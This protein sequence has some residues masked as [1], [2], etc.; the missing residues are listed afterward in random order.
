M[1]KGGGSHRGVPAVLI[2]LGALLC[3]N[4]LIY[5]YLDSLYQ[6]SNL[7]EHLYGDCPPGHFRVG[8]MRNCS[9]WLQCEAV[10]KEVRKLKMISQGAVKQV[11]LS[12]W[13]G[14]KVALSKLSSLDY[15]EDFLHGLEMLKALQSP[16]VVTLVGFCLDNHTIVT[17][18]QPL[19]SLLNLNAV[20]NLEK[21]SNVNTWQNRFRL[22]I[23]Y[24]EI[25]AFLHNSP[26]GVRVMC[27]SN[28]LGK[29]LSQYLLTTDFHLVANDLD[30]LPL[31]DHD[32]NIL[33]KCGP[34]ELLGEFVAPE[35][36]WPHGEE[37]QFTDGLMP[38]YDEKTDIWKIPDVV[39]F[40][41]G[42]VEGSDVVHFHLFDT[43]AACKNRDPSQR[44]SAQE[45]LKVY[46]TVF[47]AMMK[48]SPT[49][50]SRDML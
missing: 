29:T 15:Q 23:E 31:V 48:D 13:K 12:E 19:G 14:H 25:Q 27:D 50:H 5:L 35:Q 17:E 1:V 33:A 11:F 37:L 3:A 7:H 18:Y 45:V 20:L 41:L 26:M 8:A 47:A 2:C 21:Y 38:G 30:A 4:V 6:G 28:D 49:P 34:R 40:L 39:R 36:L 43:H 44:P 46:R 24:V 42:Q 22:A 10:L 9:P 16:Y 32:A